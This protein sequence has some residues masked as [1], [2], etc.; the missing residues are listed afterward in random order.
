[1]AVFVGVAIGAVGCPAAEA[2]KG[3]A[4]NASEKAAPSIQS[5]VDAILNEAKEYSIA[6]GGVDYVKVDTTF[7]KGHPVLAIHYPWSVHRNA[8]VEVLAMK[9]TDPDTAEIRPMAFVGTQLKDETRLAFYRVFNA[10]DDTATEK[11]IVKDETEMQIFGDRNHLGKIAAY[12]LFPAKP[13]KTQQTPYAIYPELERWA[14]D[15]QTLRI[16]LP[17]EHFAAPTRLR[18][19]FLREG[20][21]VWRQTIAWPGSKA[22]NADKSANKSADKN[23]AKPGKRKAAAPKDE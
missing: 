19:W 21:V 13:G 17:A 8:S 7:P 9:K 5:Q 14:S 6:P 3:D 20:N 4:T 18:V 11:T 10:A 22:V 12:V 2:A 1:V 23:A 15:P 16:E